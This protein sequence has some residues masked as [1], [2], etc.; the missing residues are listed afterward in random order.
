MMEFHDFTHEGLPWGFGT[1]IWQ[2][3]ELHPRHHQHLQNEQR[4]RE[5][6]ALWEDKVSHDYP[7]GG[8]SSK[9]AFNSANREAVS[10]IPELLYHE[11]DPQGASMHIRFPWL[12]HL[13][14]SYF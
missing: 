6:H 13:L 2:K 14:H 5:E 8:R 9:L 1:G 12:S 11:F 4:H 3:T 10:S 7:W